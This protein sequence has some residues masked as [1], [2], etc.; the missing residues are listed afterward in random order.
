[1]QVGGSY[2]T[3]SRRQEVTLGE[4]DINRV[5]VQYIKAMEKDQ[6]LYLT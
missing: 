1:V 4:E 3:A 6:D 2:L 5:C